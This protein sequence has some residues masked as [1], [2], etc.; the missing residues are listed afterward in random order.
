MD[1]MSKE[2]GTENYVD[3]SD[4]TQRENAWPADAEGDKVN[5]SEFARYSWFMSNTTSTIKSWLPVQYWVSVTE[6]SIS[7]IVSGDASASFQ[8]RLISFAYFG[9]IKPFTDPC[10]GTEVAGQLS[11][12]TGNFGMCVSSDIAPTYSDRYSD[13]TG[14]GV[15]DIVMLKTASG[16]PMQAHNVAFTTPDEFVDKSLEGP[17][18][19][20][21]KYHM[22]PA[23]V[24]HGFDGYRGEIDTALVTDRSAIV[25]LDDM[26]VDKGKATQK[27]YKA[28][29]VN[30]PYSIF[31]T[32]PNVLYAV[33]I[34]KEEGLTTE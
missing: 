5:D 1:G 20:T 9:K 7:M 13:K 16:F 28:F 17:S 34:L 15:V 14:T 18:A 24:F 6:D 26:V 22:S 30:A 27:I 11:D 19:W 33:A 31:N 23:Y 29:M 3:L 32:S 2:P 25:H 12:P 4:P 8:D 21:R 10:S